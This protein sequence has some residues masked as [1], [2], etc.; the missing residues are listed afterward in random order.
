MVLLLSHLPGVGAFDAGMRNLAD[1]GLVVLLDRL[2]LVEK[3]PILGVC[4][5]MQLM[6]REKSEEGTLLGL[7][8]LAADTIRF[9][10]PATGGLR[11]PHVGWSQVNCL[12]AT[13]VLLRRC[14][15]PR[16]Y[17]VP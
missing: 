15:E 17:F 9:R 1:R 4:L 11:V 10:F 5:G 16:F 2:V 6:S 3:I 14:T 12:A 7:G 8:W 13:S